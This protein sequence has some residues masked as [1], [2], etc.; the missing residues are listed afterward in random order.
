MN[1]KGLKKNS[2]HK[3]EMHK[4]NYTVN[5]DNGVKFIKAIE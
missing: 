2:I 4:H 1:R 3:R 5:F